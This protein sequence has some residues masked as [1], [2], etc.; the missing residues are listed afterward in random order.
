MSIEFN[1]IIFLVILIINII[2]CIK[3]IPILGLSVGFFTIL[4]SGAIFFND[5][6][7][8]VFFTY[9]LI[10]I[11]FSCMI[12]NGLDVRRKK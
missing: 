8:N 12:I 6:N 2:L 9:F 10:V 4:L 3:R 7:I 5:V 1:G 11:G